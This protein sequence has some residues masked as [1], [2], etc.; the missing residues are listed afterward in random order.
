MAGGANA[1]AEVELE[2]RCFSGVIPV[3]GKAGG[4]RMSQGKPAERATH[5]TLGGKRQEETEVQ[6]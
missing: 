3:K 6:I 5:L 1:D 4:S 2:D